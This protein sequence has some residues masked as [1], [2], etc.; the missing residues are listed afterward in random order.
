MALKKVYKNRVLSSRFVFK[1]GHE[2]A[3]VLGKYFT[4][5]E[6]EITELE[7]EIKVGHPFLYIDPDETEIDSENVDPLSEVRRK[8]VE[9]YIATQNAANQKTNDRGIS[10][11]QPLTP[12]NST[13]VSEGAAGS[14]A[15]A[16][17]PAVKK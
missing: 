12:A 1:D 9:E 16:S 4:D 2:A 14:V 3:F 17:A 13:T 6:A 7:H 15:E 10:V 5:V 11:A 8:A